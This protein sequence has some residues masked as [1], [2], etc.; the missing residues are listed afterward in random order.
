VIALPYSP[1]GRTAERLLDRLRRDVL[2]VEPRGFDP[3][4]V[5]RA[6]AVQVIAGQA[7]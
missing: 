6:R 4:V 7:K 5:P 3:R 2:I 1:F